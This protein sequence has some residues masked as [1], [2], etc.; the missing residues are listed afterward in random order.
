MRYNSFTVVNSI[1]SELGASGKPTVAVINKT[2]LCGDI[3]TLP[4]EIEGCNKT[5]FVSLKENTGTDILIDAIE[6]TVPGKKQEVTLLIPY[7]QG[8]LLPALHTDQ[9]VISEEYTADGTKVVAL[10]DEICYN[11]MRDYIVR[12]ENLN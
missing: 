8:A 2:D 3:A 9:M 6:D 10:I 12:H 4:K 5:V 1:L 7:S 11:K